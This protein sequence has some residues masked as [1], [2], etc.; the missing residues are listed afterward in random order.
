[1]AKLFVLIGVVVSEPTEAVITDRFSK[2]SVQIETRETFNEK[3]YTDTFNVDFV[4]ASFHNLP[5]DPGIVGALVSVEGTIKSS[6]GFI[7][8]RG[9]AFKIISGNGNVQVSKPKID[10]QAQSQE[11]DDED[12]PF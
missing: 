10:Y 4:G 5:L 3:D 11:I 6:K 8:L 1:M 12:L 7:N 9:E 2:R